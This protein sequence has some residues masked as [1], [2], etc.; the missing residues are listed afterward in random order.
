M[1]LHLLAPG[2]ALAA[3]LSYAG[4]SNAQTSNPDSAYFDLGRVKLQKNFTQNVTIKGADLHRFPFTNLSEAVNVWFNGNFTS[5]SNLVYVVDGKLLT[6]ANQYPIQDIE[7]ITLVQNAVGAINGDTQQQQLILIKTKRNLTQSSGIEVSGQ[8]NLVQLQKRG[9]F[10]IFPNA[11]TNTKLFQQYNLSAFKNFNKVHVGL[12]ANY[13]RDI[14]PV[15]TMGNNQYISP[16]NLDRWRLNGYL[17]A[18]VWK[19]STLDINVGYT[20]QSEDEHSNIY[21]N[22]SVIN[23][24]KN[25]I[26]AKQFNSSLSLLSTIVPGLTNH[27]KAG[28]VRSKY[29][30]ENWGNQSLNSTTYTY[31]SQNNS[32]WDNLLLS[33]E[34]RY[35]HQAGDITFSPAVNFSYRYLFNLTDYTNTLQGQ[36]VN[37][38]TSRT[39]YKTSLLT[40]TLDISY[41]DL[42]NVSGGFQYIVRTE[43]NPYVDG[44]KKVFPFITASFDAARLVSESSTVSTKVYASYALSNNFNDYHYSLFD[45]AAQPGYILNS[46]TI[47]GSYP[48][49]AA[50]DRAFKTL[51]L[52][53]D[54]GLLQNK[55]TLTYNYEKRKNVNFLNANYYISNDYYAALVFSD[56]KTLS[57]RISI[58][59]NLVSQHNF[60]WQTSLNTTSTKYN[61]SLP[62]SYL[63]YQLTG[64]DFWTGGFTN[65]LQCKNW[66]GGIDMLYMFGKNGN[67]IAQIQ[68]LRSFSLQNAYVGYN[69]KTNKLK[70]LEVYANGRNLLQNERSAFNNYSRYFGLGFKAGI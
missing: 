19:G 23:N 21:S 40:P 16:P 11:Q 8:A 35:T 63:E 17:N 46:S 38:G 59:Y 12:S 41:K 26:E 33:D 39:K 66:V 7:E 32:K 64:K 51:S 14:L 68:N 58:A 60:K 43:P 36:Q 52:G 15:K 57:H 22:N 55:L 70:N 18:E 5:A 65:R 53:T 6:D 3:C 28:Y 62:S 31:G 47:G 2:L 54:V 27:I 4:T 49:P 45:L 42:I 50:P 44:Y 25:Q 1:R 34:L 24:V 30:Q 9:L 10:E 69:I 20:P 13:Q 37:T 29:M 61:I 67:P 56:T 48:M